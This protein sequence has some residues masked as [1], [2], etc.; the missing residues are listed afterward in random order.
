M[1]ADS[2][3]GGTTSVSAA[4]VGFS[5]VA[6]AAGLLGGDLGLVLDFALAFALASAAELALALPPLATEAVIS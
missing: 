5:A 6:S 1:K 2:G 4:F 3:G